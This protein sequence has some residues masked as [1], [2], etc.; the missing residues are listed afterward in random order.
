MPFPSL[1]WKMYIFDFIF[2]IYMSI[3]LF[4]LLT[5]FFKLHVFL[6]AVLFKKKKKKTVEDKCIIFS[7]YIPI[8]IPDTMLT[9]TCTIF[10]KIADAY[11][12]LIIPKSD[13]DFIWWTVWSLFYV[14][15]FNS[16]IGSTSKIFPN[17]RFIKGYSI[18]KNDWKYSRHQS[19][20]GALNYT[21]AIIFVQ[22]M[23]GCKL[24][25]LGCHSYASWM[26]CDVKATQYWLCWNNDYFSVFYE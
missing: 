10:K 20:N 1:Q 21:V 7:L 2:K 4:I 25:G 3:V 13:S 16:F 18:Y 12:P 14:S 11:S 17:I 15:Y 8:I 26:T 24:H 6:I 19:P 9:S 5:V 22:W 23:H